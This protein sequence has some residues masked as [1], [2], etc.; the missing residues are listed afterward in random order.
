MSSELAKASQ[1]VTNHW[2]EAHEVAD[3]LAENKGFWRSCSGCHEANEGCPTGPWSIVLECNLGH[4]CHECGGI[5]A[6][7]DT[8]DYADMGDF[9]AS[10][11]AR[12]EALEVD[13]R[14]VLDEHSRIIEI[15]KDHCKTINSYLVLNSR[16]EDQI[17]ALEAENAR[18][19]EALEPF[20]RY[21]SEN[22]FGLDNNGAPLPDTDGV[23]WIYLTNGDFRAARRAREGGNA[24]G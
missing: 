21:A 13:L 5:G 24:D 16:Q 23:G 18:M 15:N 7:W 9:L 8:T 1:P 14:R 17:K 6:V 12:I 4:G 10:E 22:G 11:P 3:I 20:A 2:P 19:R